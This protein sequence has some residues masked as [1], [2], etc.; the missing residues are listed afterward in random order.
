MSKRVVQYII[1]VLIDEDEHDDDIQQ[2][3]AAL[4]TIGMEI[5]GSDTA[6]SWTE[7][8]YQVYRI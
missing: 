3:E 6:I 5:V 1:D 8:E 2:I 7:D 4:N